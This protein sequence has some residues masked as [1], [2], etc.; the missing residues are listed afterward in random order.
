[1][2]PSEI[3][4]GSDS[5]VPHQCQPSRYPRCNRCVFLRG[6]HSTP[7]IYS[8]CGGVNGAY[9]RQRG[10]NAEGNQGHKDPAPDYSDGL[11]ISE[12]DIEGRAQ[13][14]GRGDDGEGSVQGFRQQ[15]DSD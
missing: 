12:T 4:T 3:D 7:V 2:R 9:F 11:A 1:M 14:V 8:S 13:T 15:G 5:P 10:G 6:E